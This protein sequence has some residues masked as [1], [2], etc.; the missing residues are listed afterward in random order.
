ME[1]RAQ[2]WTLGGLADLLGGELHGPADLPIARPA[3]AHGEDPQGIAFC[4]SD[5]YI[6]KAEASG[7][8]AILVPR[9]ATTHKPSIAVDS[10]RAAF[11]MLLA[12][13]ARPL[14]LNAGV[15]ATAVVSAEA[16]VHETA[17]IGPYAV[18]ERGA[19]IGAG[20]R[21]YPFA[22][23]GEDCDVGDQ[24]TIYPHAVLYQDVEIG[25]R[26]IIH[27]GAILGADGFGFVWDGR[28]RVK[29]PQVGRVEIGADC[30]IGAGTTI[31]RATAG[32]TRI[33]R[34]T[35]LDNLVQIGQDRKSVV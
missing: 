35:K 19:R 27:A 7:V 18:V 32:A 34:G 1:K 4:E 30:E 25:A 17:A 10:P 5:D 6:A 3:P 29:V 26:T 23:I 15:H 12:M 13:A 16:Q 2:P 9:G 14:P 24:A 22:Y 21:I 31:D 8:G 33:G 11:G 28:R 20:V